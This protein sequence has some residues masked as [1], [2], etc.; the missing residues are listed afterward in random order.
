MDVQKNVMEDARHLA[1]IVPVIVEFLVEI[2]HNNVPKIAEKVAPIHAEI[3]L[4]H[5]LVVPEDVL[6][7]M[8]HVMVDVLH[9][10]PMIAEQIVEICVVQIIVLELV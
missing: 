8:V 9:N 1:V 3:V 2:V 7:V 6:V 10:A 5:V 4:V